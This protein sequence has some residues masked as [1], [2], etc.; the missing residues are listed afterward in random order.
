MKSILIYVLSFGFLLTACI[1]EQIV[2]TSSPEKGI[3][4]ISLDKNNSPK[5]ITEIVLIL[6]RDGF[7]TI[8]KSIN[9]NANTSSSFSSTDLPSGIWHIVVQALNVNHEV[10]YSGETDIS[11]QPDFSISVFLQF[12]VNTG[13]LIFNISLGETSTGNLIALY[14]FYGNANDLSGNNNGI[15][16]G[17]SLVADRFGNQKSAYYFDGVDDY[18]RIP[19]HSSLTPSDQ[20]FSIASW[21][22]VVDAKNKYILYKGTKFNNRE[23][24]LGVR[25][26]MRA[27]FHIN[28]HGQWQSGQIG[29]SSDLFLENEEWIFIASTWNG[30]EL[31]IYLNGKLENIIT[32]TAVIEDFDSD[33]FIG[34]YGGEI[35]RYAFKGV[36]DDIAIF[37]KPL[38]ATEIEQIYHATK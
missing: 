7:E 14:P 19:D 36:I 2:D 26:D 4:S 30:E 9:L 6:E 33:L 31:K 18:I 29:V 12:D 23:Y 13:N 11:I 24:A 37:N 1:S 21:V 8:R 28:D 20:Q 35:E 10:L 16:E 22:K 3:V 5:D 32:T 27:S 34:T 25:T 15:V 38:S 17:A